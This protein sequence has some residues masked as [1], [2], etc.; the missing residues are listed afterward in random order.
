MRKFCKAVLILGLPVSMLI[1]ACGENDDTYQDVVINEPAPVIDP[2]DPKLRDGIGR[3]EAVPYIA[4]NYFV[5]KV[6]R[7]AL[8]DPSMLAQQN[9]YITADNLGLYRYPSN[10]V[11]FDDETISTQTNSVGF[12]LIDDPEFFYSAAASVLYDKNNREA[13]I[14]RSEIDETIGSYINKFK[15]RI[16]DDYNVVVGAPQP[17]YGIDGEMLNIEIQVSKKGSTAVADKFP[18]IN[19]KRIRDELISTQLQKDAWTTPV[20]SHAENAESKQVNVELTIWSYKGGVY[21][22]TAAYDPDGSYEGDI[23]DNVARVETKYGRFNNGTSISSALHALAIN[24]GIDL[25]GNRVDSEG[26]IEG[27]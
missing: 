1:T 8:I 11:A 20:L 9:S 23:V 6:S 21:L 24:E 27:N 22:W 15:R 3:T 14:T 26:N 10:G 18:V 5:D 19:Y 16:G 17:Y 2:N 12:L 4:G 7:I 25:D 13:V